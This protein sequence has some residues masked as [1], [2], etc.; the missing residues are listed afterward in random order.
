MRN[1]SSIFLKQGV[2]TI[3]HFQGGKTK[4]MKKTLSLALTLALTTSAFAGIAGAATTDLTATQKFEALKTAGIFTGIND[5]G[6]AGLDQAM[7][8]AQ[9]ARV[10]GLLL[11]LDVNTK[12]AK[13]LFQD[14]SLTHWAVEE[15]HAINA[16]GVM[17]GNG[18]STFT[19]EAKVTIEQVA[20]VLVDATKLTVDP[21]AVVPGASSWA[22]GYVKAAVDA[23][24]ISATADFKAYANRE[25]LVNSTYAVYQT[26]QKLSVTE[27]KA[28]GV[29]TVNVTF[30]KAVDTAVTKLALTRGT[31]A[32]ATTAVFSEDKKSAV[33]TLTDVRVGEGQYTVTVSGVDATA[34]GKATAEFTGQNEVVNK[35]EFVNTNDT[36][37]KTAATGKT[38]AVKAR[39]LNQYNENASTTA[40]N[41]ILISAAPTNVSKDTDGS[42]IIKV[43]TSG[44]AFPAGVGIVSITII[45][46][47]SHISATK[48]FKIGT[49]PILSKLELGAPKYSVGT[50]L[51]ATG[52]NVKYALSLFD[53]YGNLVTF[54]QLGAAATDIPLPTVFWNDYVTGVTTVVE[55]DGNNLPV[56]K[57]SLTA[58]VDKS[59]DYAFTVIDQAANA[60]GK[61]SIQSSKVVTKIAIGEMNNVI[62]AHDTDVYIPVIGYDAQGTQLS[63]NDL[64]SAANVARIT[65]AVAGATNPI[66]G[67]IVSTGEHKGTIHLTNI[68]D[69]KNGAVSVNLFIATANASSNASKTYTIQ[70]ARVPDHFKEATAPAVNAVE[71]AYSAFKY[72]VVDQYGAQLDTSL[73]VDA[74][75]NYNIG[76]IHYY[77]AVTA[78]TVTSAGVAVAI[79]KATANTGNAVVTADTSAVGTQALFDGTAVLY[80]NGTGT[81]TEPQDFVSL[82]STF[83]F[84]APAGSVGQKVTFNA[85]LL[86]ETGATD[87]VISSL[88][89]TLTVTAASGTSAL[90]YTL[91]DVAALWNAVDSGLIADNLNY[92]GVDPGVNNDLTVATQTTAISSAFGREIVVAATNASG[93]TVA[94]PKTVIAVTSSNPTIA[95]VGYDS[96]AKKAFVVGN[97]AGTATVGVS[98][99]AADGTIKTLTKEV[100]VKSDALAVASVSWDDASKARVV[101]TN[102]FAGLNV[103]DNY[104]KGYEDANAQA[105]NYLLGVSFAINNVVGGSVVLDQFGNITAASTV[106]ATF[107]LVVVSANGK[108]ATQ[109]VTLN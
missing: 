44:T 77:V 89:K 38:V 100:T 95:R 56:L 63:I 2:Q 47:D 41:Y 13:S 97:K 33:L 36:I 58:N 91:N 96:V 82:N 74:N 12:P 52:E 80:G 64:V 37:A 90:T 98:F 85:Q 15:I 84:V 101:G 4:V 59:A 92:D 72:V 30:N 106:G 48:T 60:V 24:F 11:G 19:P 66:A 5:A 20:R 62:A 8:R 76:G 14:V 28:V 45:N 104:G 26:S 103:T 40:G 9:F 88:S 23:G 10:A 67:R 34:I 35:I 54:D 51:S 70:A 18:N 21:A 81:P 93:E 105:F 27:A 46:D 65:V 102:V 94:L 29:K 57:L 42:L 25:L 107:E 6:D 49:T 61:V 83:R 108:T 16:V 68:G 7:T 78:S 99:I 50:A 43:D 32:V 75:G 86:K 39:A 53:Q 22:Q 31:V 69:N 17:Q 109:S 55:N 73:N 3:K 79:T 87:T 1:T 71:G